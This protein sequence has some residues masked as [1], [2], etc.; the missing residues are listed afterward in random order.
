MTIQKFG[1]QLGCVTAFCIGLSWCLS[2]SV[3]VLRQHLLAAWWAVVLFVLLS[4]LMFIFGRIA[5]SAIN[6]K[7]FSQLTIFFTLTKLLT[8]V[9]SIVIYKSKIQP[10]DKWFVVPF[11][12]VYIIFTIFE[13]YFMF[14][15]S[16]LPPKK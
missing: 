12:M 6:K 15:L 11:L 9:A 1:W 5:A 3:L 4:V 10:L 2:A 7:L 16:Q 14:Q 8:S 13:T